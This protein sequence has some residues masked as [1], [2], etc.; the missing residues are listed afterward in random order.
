MSG[1]LPVYSWE[2]DVPFA[3]ATA[4]VSR[5]VAPK[6]AT[7]FNHSATRIPG[8]EAL[9]VDAGAVGGLSGQDFVDRQSAQ[10]AQRGFH[11]K[12]TKLARP[13]HVSGVGDADSP[14]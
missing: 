5:P 3:G 1:S 4:S 14:T 11:T 13:H 10:A 2:K 8:Q 9:L 7:A 6:T 12:W